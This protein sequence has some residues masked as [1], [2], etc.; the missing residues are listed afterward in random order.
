[1]DLILSRVCGHCLHSKVEMGYGKDSAIWYECSLEPGKKVELEDQACE[2][3]A[4]PPEED[5]E[6][7]RAKM[8]EV[9]T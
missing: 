2:Q 8:K 4:S 5:I 3:W 7:W 1:M 6:K 9:A